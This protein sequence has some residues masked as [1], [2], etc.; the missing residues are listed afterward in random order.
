MRRIGAQVDLMMTFRDIECLCELPRA[1]TQPAKIIHSAAFPHRVDPTARLERADEDEA[2][3]RSA[4]HKHVQHPVHAVIEIDISRARFVAP[5]ELARARPAEGV[6]GFV[7]LDQIRFSLDHD[8][9]ASSPDKLGSDQ[10][11]GALQR[12]EFKKRFRQH[13]A[14]VAGQA[15]FGRMV[16]A[17]WRCTT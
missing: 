3:A 2:L 7:A 13:P 11:P 8:A 14:K 5:N 9:R 4:F 16:A 17:G 15:A 12:I 1:R 6:T 10:V